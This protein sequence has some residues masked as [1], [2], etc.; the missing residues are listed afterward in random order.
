MGG[1][2]NG[3]KYTSRNVVGQE[4]E[5][6][7]EDDIIK[8]FFALPRSVYSCVLIVKVNAYIYT[9]VMFYGYECRYLQCLTGSL[10]V[11]VEGYFT[12]TISVQ[13]TM[14]CRER[15]SRNSRKT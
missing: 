13:S 1:G 3:S 4:E 8:T 5:D 11:V 6:I 2:R 15:D 10:F 9:R 7:D 14:T 12:F